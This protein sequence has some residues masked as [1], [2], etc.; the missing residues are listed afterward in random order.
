MA[1]PRL[2]SPVYPAP[3]YI[4]VGG[5]C[6]PASNQECLVDGQPRVAAAENTVI[7]RISS[8]ADQFSPHP[9]ALAHHARPVTVR[10][11]EG[12]SCGLQLGYQAPASR[13]SPTRSGHASAIQH[14]NLGVPTVYQGGNVP[15]ATPVS[16]KAYSADVFDGGGLQAA[17]PQSRPY[18][19]E[20]YSPEGLQVRLG[21][22]PANRPHFQIA[23]GSS[24]ALRHAAE[25]VNIC[26]SECRTPALPPH[27]QA[28]SGPSAQ[29]CSPYTVYHPFR[30]SHASTKVSP[31]HEID[32]EERKDA[33]DASWT[34]GAPRCDAVWTGR[35]GERV[36]QNAGA[37]YESPH[38]MPEPEVLGGHRQSAALLPVF[39][40]HDEIIDHG[41][42]FGGE[43]PEVSKQCSQRGGHIL[44]FLSEEEDSS[45][46]FA[47]LK[48]RE[49]TDL[50]GWR[51]LARQARVENT[52][53]RG[54]I[55]ECEKQVF[56]LQ[57]QVDRETARSAAQSKTQLAMEADLRAAREE[58]LRLRHTLRMNQR[59]AE[60]TRG[61]TIGGGVADCSREVFLM[62]EALAEAAEYHME[63][64]EQNDN[65]RVQIEWLRRGGGSTAAPGSKAMEKTAWNEQLRDQ[66]RYE[67]E[68]LRELFCRHRNAAGEN[69]GCSGVTKLDALSRSQQ[70]DGGVD[71]QSQNASSGHRQNGSNTAGDIFSQT[72]CSDA[73]YRAFVKRTG[74]GDWVAQ[75]TVLT[76]K[77]D[78]SDDLSSSSLTLPCSPTSSSKRGKPSTST[79]TRPFFHNTPGEGEL[80][81]A[82]SAKKRDDTGGP[83][84][85]LEQR[86][87]EYQSKAPGATAA[88]TVREGSPRYVAASRRDRDIPEKQ[89]RQEASNGRAFD[90]LA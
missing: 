17:S 31:S 50:E 33:Q 6:T 39:V 12:L 24:P 84:K 66:E 19:F 14:G 82:D 55:Q 69:E 76:S 78:T 8:S 60:L 32:G 71:D 29:A 35:D 58:M 63:L 20:T 70:G 30:Q 10:N 86:I 18:F 46:V 13:Y 64:I 85:R 38:G 74:S 25:Y 56:T 88:T 11:D 41:K 61:A 65:L 7:H 47:K 75:G 68:Q 53:L 2:A 28:T 3:Q 44:S 52:V 72:A 87:R 54:R 22:T 57:Q 4:R 77:R 79:L 9:G 40:K 83:I 48:G 45:T 42:R 27:L 67:L 80:F 23:G 16:P 73:G 51:E 81:R 36:V 62:R 90:A 43:Q 89:P 37:G 5:P 49:P 15:Q 59:G 21:Q 1:D 34:A 26:N